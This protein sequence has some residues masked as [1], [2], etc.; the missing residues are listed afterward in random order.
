M[1]GPQSPGFARQQPK[2]SRMRSLVGVFTAIR[3]RNGSALS[4]PWNQFP[5]RITLSTIFTFLLGGIATYVFMTPRGPKDRLLV[6]AGG[7]P[8]PT[9]PPDS[10][11][12][13]RVQPAPQKHASAVGGKL[14]DINNRF[15]EANRII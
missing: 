6:P 5:R 1:S 12:A 10:M 7:N 11:P 4:V 3:A 8:L 14:C 13:A 2:Q 15:M 9:P